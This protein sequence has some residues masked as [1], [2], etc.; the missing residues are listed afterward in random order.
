MP[1]INVIKPS[2]YDSFQCVGG[3]CRQSCCSSWNITLSKEEFKKTKK[4]LQSDTVKEIFS[5]AF[6][7]MSG[8][9]LQKTN[10]YKMRLKENGDCPFLDEQ[11][12]CWIYRD[13]GPQIMS[14]TCRIFPRFNIMYDKKRLDCALTIGCEEVVRLLLE[15]K[16]GFLLQ[17]EE[18]EI[19][20]E[21]LNEYESISPLTFIKKPLL[22]EYY[23]VRGLLLGVLQNREYDMGERMILLGIALQKIDAMDKENKIEEVAKYIDHFLRSM[24]APENKKIYQQFFEK[25]QRDVRL[26]ALNTLTKYYSVWNL[27]YLKKDIKKKI[28]DRIDVDM[29]FFASQQQKTEDD[30]IILDRMK[31]HF[32][33]EKYAQA[34]EYFLNWQKENAH[35]LENIIVA[36]AWQ[37]K[38]PFAYGKDIWKNYCA[39][40]LMYSIFRF[41]LAMF[42]TEDTTHEDMIDCIVTT[43]R[44]ILHNDENT[45]KL[46]DELEDTQ[47]NT[48]AHMAMLVL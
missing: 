31:Y 20:F 29:R 16:E 22:K 41:N 15:E 3:V 6:L 18:K 12:L 8:N 11:R 26:R 30:K 47:S 42:I 40:A 38:L 34:E 27:N 35:V 33:G 44:S 21:E 39:F 1:K 24:N 7:P 13:C 17:T 5:N 37:K 25:I 43:A 4:A 9:S 36:L 45:K 32:D 2:F 14:R 19:S 10:T 23:T 46:E 48:L 28:F